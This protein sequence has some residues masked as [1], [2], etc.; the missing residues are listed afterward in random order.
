MTRMCRIKS[1]FCIGVMLAVLLTGCTQ[2]QPEQ[3][4]PINDKLYW[5]IDRVK[6]VENSESGITSRKKTDGYFTVRFL[7]EGLIEEYKVS[8]SRLM[9]RIDTQQLMGLVINDEGVIT[10]IRPARETA[11]EIVSNCYVQQ[12]DGKTY[13][14]NSMP[15]GTGM[16]K[17]F[18]VTDETLILDVS[19]WSADPGKPCQIEHLDCVW[20]FGN[21]DGTAKIVFVL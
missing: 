9:V 5:N 10:D 15:D 20:V 3:T 21:E 11:H 14:T 4:E 7:V 19:K 2:Q 6:Y 18:T 1:I 12:I 8:D 17:D 13:K 16:K